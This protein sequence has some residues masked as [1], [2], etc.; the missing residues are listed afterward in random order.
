MRLTG[1]YLGIMSG[2]GEMSET[3]A[4]VAAAIEDGRMLDAW[5]RAQA[6]GIELAA[7]PHGEGRRTAARLAANLGDGRRGQALDWLNWRQDRANPKWYFHALFPR[8]GSRTPQELMA[9]IEGRL[10]GDMPDESRAELLAYLAWSPF[11]SG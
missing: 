6:S 4:A 1:V 10:K 7:W 2:V 3:V 11:A 5:E 8:S 9:E